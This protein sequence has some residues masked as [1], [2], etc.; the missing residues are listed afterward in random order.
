MKKL[1]LF[2]TFA[3]L[4][5]LSQAQIVSSTSRTITKETTEKAPSTSVTYIRADYSIDGAYGKDKGDNVKGKSGFVVGVGWNSAV[6]KF[7]WGFEVGGQTRGFATE[8]NNGKY[9][10]NRTHYGLYGS[11]LAGY[12]FAVSPDITIDPALSFGPSFDLAGSLSSS[13]KDVDKFIKEN[14]KWGEGYKKFDLALSVGAKLWYKNKY[15]FQLQYRSGLLKW[16]DTSA[17]VKFN[18]QKFTIG[19]GIAI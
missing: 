15:F 14:A 18:A 9:T 5:T 6:Q 12:K 16:V 10:N 11:V 4:T 2:A 1:F 8:E 3:A 7:Y 17:D 13:N 19:L